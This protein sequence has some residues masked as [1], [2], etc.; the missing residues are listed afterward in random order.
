[1]K[2]KKFTGCMAMILLFTAFTCGVFAGEE[3]EGKLNLNTATVKELVKVPGLNQDLAAKIIELREKNGEFI[4]MEELLD[5]PGINNELL[6]QLKK[7]LYIESVDD[8]N[9]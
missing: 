1:M 7:H 2:L 8:C 5:V 4:D 9:C 3:N 6:R